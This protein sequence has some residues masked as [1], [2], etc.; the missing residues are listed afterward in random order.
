VCSVAGRQSSE[1]PEGAQTNTHPPRDAR[2]LDGRNLAV[3]NGRQNGQQHLRDILDRAQRRQ[4]DAQ[5]L[6]R[7]GRSERR[8]QQLRGE[9]P[10]QIGLAVEQIRQR[11]GTQRSGHEIGYAPLG[12]GDAARPAPWV[13]G[14][15]F[16]EALARVARA[17]QEG[18]RTK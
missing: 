18:I 9:G 15:S 7:V 14:A 13:A 11:L 12:I 2:S 8:R 4:V 5:S 10:Q 6:G 1:A 16:G 17:R 3:R